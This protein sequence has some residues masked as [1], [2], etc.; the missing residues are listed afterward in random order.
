MK[1]TL[2]T[3]LVMAASVCTVFAQD[4]KATAPV[5]APA[6]QPGQ[7]TAAIK[8]AQ[9][10]QDQLVTELKLTDDQQKKIAD[11]NKAF[12]ERRKAIENNAEL[13]DEAKA[14]RKAMLRK[15]LET[16]FLQLLTTEQ[17]ARYK[18]LLEAKNKKD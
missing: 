16:Q 13:T 7:K 4:Q 12:G 14:E 15:A 2:L 1:R 5:A 18:E 8:Q 11:L 17:Q 6:A 10:W 9:D 3:A